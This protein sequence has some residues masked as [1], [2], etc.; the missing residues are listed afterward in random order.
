MSEDIP[1]EEAIPANPIDAD[2]PEADPDEPPHLQH[3]SPHE[4]RPEPYDPPNPQ[5]P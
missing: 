3:G 5:V 2:D 4:D 1:P